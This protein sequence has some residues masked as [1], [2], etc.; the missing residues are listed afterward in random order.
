LALLILFLISDFLSLT[1]LGG[2]IPIGM[3]IILVAAYLIGRTKY[4][5]LSSAVTLVAL[6]I[7]PYYILLSSITL[8]SEKLFGT[9]AW[10]PWI[11]L[12]ASFISGPILTLLLAAANLLVLLI[13]PALH[14]GLTLGMIGFSIAFLFAMAVVIVLG[15]VLRES[16]LNKIMAQR[17]ELAR[18]N[19]ELGLYMSLLRHDFRNDIGIILGTVDLVTMESKDETTKVEMNSIEALGERMLHLLSLISSTSAQ[20]EQEDI[21]I[22]IENVASKAMQVHPKLQIKVLVSESARNTHYIASRLLPLVFENLFRNSASYAGD[23]PVVIVT[24]HREGNDLIIDIRDNGPG[25]DRM[26]QDKLFEKGVSTSGPE[27]GIGLYLSK[28]V[29]VSHGGSIEY[30]QESKGAAFRIILIA[31]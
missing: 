13:L 20:D 14:S 3:P 18:Q 31:Y 22:M 25:V 2:A 29:I 26:I 7:M 19:N 17:L 12:L 16:N 5:H 27:K 10:I 9:L 8:T 21:A 28:K 4:I 11:I 15:S 1:V 24:V 30:L 6:S 23:N